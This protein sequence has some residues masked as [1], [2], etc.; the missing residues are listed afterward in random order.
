VLEKAKTPVKK[1]KRKILISE[2]ISIIILMKLEVGLKSLR[3]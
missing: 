2:N 1:I 3:K